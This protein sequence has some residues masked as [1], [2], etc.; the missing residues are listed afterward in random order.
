MDVT[1]LFSFG[2][3]E[4]IWLSDPS[5]VEF[6]PILLRASLDKSVAFPE[7]A[8]FLQGIQIFFPRRRF[9]NSFS[10][11]IIS[12]VPGFKPCTLSLHSSLLYSL[13]PSDRIHFVVFISTA[14]NLVQAA[15]V[16]P[17]CLIFQYLMK[18]FP[19]LHGPVSCSIFSVI[20]TDVI[21][22]TSSFSH[23]SCFHL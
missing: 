5:P 16:R 4:Q 20:I 18:G 1:Q 17:R 7:R 2:R 13:R 21:N 19:S 23:F 8:W 9:N 15:P 12:V 10:A 22:H 6:V 3:K 11:A 14:T